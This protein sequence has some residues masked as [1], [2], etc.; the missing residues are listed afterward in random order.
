MTGSGN[1]I[2]SSAIGDLLVAERIAGARV[3]ESDRGRDVARADRID[4]LAMVGVHA[5]NAPDA[6]LAAAARVQHVAA[7]V[8]HARVDAEIR[9]VAVRIGRDLEG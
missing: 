1:V 7:L 6:L 2:D 3:G 9:E 4:I 5:Q 8:E